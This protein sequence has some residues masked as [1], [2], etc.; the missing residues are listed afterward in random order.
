MP[1]SCDMIEGC[2][3]WWQIIMLHN[4]WNLTSTAP[5]L[6]RS[7]YFL[8]LDLVAAHW[9][10][11]ATSF[12][13]CLQECS[14]AWHPWG[15]ICVVVWNGMCACLVILWQIQPKNE[16]QIRSLSSSKHKSQAVLVSCGG[17][18]CLVYVCWWF[19]PP[20]VCQIYLYLFNM[21]EV[22]RLLYLMFVYIHNGVWL[23]TILSPAGNKTG[24]QSIR[25]ID[26]HLIPLR[27]R[28]IFCSLKGNWMSKGK[29]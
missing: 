23:P 1:R 28:I 27:R 7:D 18:C 22:S 5:E 10:L 14:R 26:E 13:S 6:L 3:M 21:I 19:S 11:W 29:P 15:L 8:G 16:I 12:S 2:M 24:F 4:L 25:C 9:I 20:F 17:V